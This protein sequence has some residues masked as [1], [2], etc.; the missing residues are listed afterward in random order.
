MKTDP[1][2]FYVANLI[3]VGLAERGYLRP[4]KETFK[5]CLEYVPN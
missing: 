2:N 5:K 3:G 1:S 4:A